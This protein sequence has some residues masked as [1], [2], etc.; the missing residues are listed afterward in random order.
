MLGET[1]QLGEL[2][3]IERYNYFLGSTMRATA[4]IID[5]DEEYVYILTDNRIEDVDKSCF[6]DDDGAGT[7]IVSLDAQIE[8]SVERILGQ[9]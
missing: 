1:P 4:L 5:S 8:A 3:I 6:Y 2:V 7:W 9:V